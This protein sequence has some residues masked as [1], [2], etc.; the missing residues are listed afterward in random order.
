MEASNTIK[1]VY[2]NYKKYT[3]SAKKLG[4]VNKGKF[5]LDTMTKKFGKILDDNVPEFPKEVELNL[6]KLKKTNENKAPKIKLPKL[7]RV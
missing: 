4:I 6:P 3:L 7:K 1:D 2:V 5:S